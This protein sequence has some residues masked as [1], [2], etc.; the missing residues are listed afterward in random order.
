[1][2][3]QWCEKTESKSSW[4]L[5]F[6]SPFPPMSGTRFFQSTVIGKSSFAQFLKFFRIRVL[7]T[8]YGCQAAACTGSILSIFHQSVGDRATYCTLYTV[9]CTLHTFLY[10]TLY[11]VHYTVQLTLHTVHNTLY[12]VNCFGM[13]LKF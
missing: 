4:T 9:H 1:M 13:S 11:T 12:T 10:C 5:S 3:E 7:D 6:F 8:H 2:G